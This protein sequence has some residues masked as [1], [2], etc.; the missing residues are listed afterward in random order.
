MKNTIL[1]FAVLSSVLVSCAAG[2]YRAQADMNG[3]RVELESQ[4]RELR[5]D[6]NIRDEYILWLLSKKQNK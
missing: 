6:T 4:V 3:L 2:Y 1:F 5:R